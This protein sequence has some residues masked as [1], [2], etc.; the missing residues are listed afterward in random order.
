LEVV[1]PPCLPEMEQLL[2]W[3]E[4]HCLLVDN[5]SEDNWLSLDSIVRHHSLLI[6][7]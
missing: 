2:F 7:H 6:L 1:P 3:V 4:L 5:L